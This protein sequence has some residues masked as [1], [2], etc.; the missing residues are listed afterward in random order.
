[1]SEVTFTSG[2]RI[3]WVDDMTQGLEE[4]SVLDRLSPVVEAVARPFNQRPLADVLRGTWLGHAL[5]PL[6]T[7][8]PLGCWTSALVLDLLPGRHRRASRT[9]IG[10]GLLAVPPTAAA[11]L[12]EWDTLNR[13]EERR[14]TVVHAIGNTIV[15]GLFLKSWLDRGRGRQAAGVGWGML[16]GALALVTGYL[17]GHLSFARLVGTGHRGRPSQRPTV[18]SRGLRRQSPVFSGR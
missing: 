17:G 3:P 16:G 13:P 12:S 2:E 5:H 8:L 1:V 7:D 10:L 6:M 9:L 18:G 14:V 4:A 11:G 15:A